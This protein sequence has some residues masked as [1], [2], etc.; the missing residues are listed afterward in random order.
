M[1]VRIPPTAIRNSLDD[2]GIARAR[3]ILGS[4]WKSKCQLAV[5]IEQGIGRRAMGYAAKEY[6]I[7][8]RELISEKS[9][10]KF[11]TKVSTTF[12]VWNKA[13]VI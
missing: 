8:K 3:N 5:E 13:W 1:W 2:E 11:F 7:R 4:T 6:K 10:I 9:C 12:F